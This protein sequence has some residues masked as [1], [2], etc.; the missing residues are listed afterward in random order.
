VNPD[1]VLWQ[2]DPESP[3][4]LRAVVSSGYRASHP[5]KLRIYDS[6]QAIVKTIQTTPILG[7]G[8][9]QLEFEWNGSQDPPRMGTAPKG[10]YLFRW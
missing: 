2:G 3:V 4:T 7:P 6:D 8:A 9:S 1:P 5:V 10:L